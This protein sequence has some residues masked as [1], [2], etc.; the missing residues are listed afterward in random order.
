MGLISESESSPGEGNGNPLQNSGL[1]NS[2]GRGARQAT[3]H[4]VTKSETQ[5]RMQACVFLT[6]LRK[7]EHWRLEQ[8]NIQ[9]N[10]NQTHFWN[11]Y[12]MLKILEKK[13]MVWK[14]HQH[15]GEQM[16]QKNEKG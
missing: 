3:V 13:P 6:E 10:R 1:E 14:I 8:I 11:E 16:K 12:Y 4:E 7:I 15:L 9:S 2:M 5:P